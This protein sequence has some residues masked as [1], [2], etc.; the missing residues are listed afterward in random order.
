[1]NDLKRAGE[2][3]AALVAGAFLW[4]LGAVFMTGVRLDNFG[5]IAIFVGWNG[6]VIAIVAVGIRN[7]I[8]KKNEGD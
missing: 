7:A 3:I 4:F 2:I 8:S 6:L 5:D 1:M